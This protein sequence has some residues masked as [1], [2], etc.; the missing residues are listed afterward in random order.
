MGTIWAIGS[1]FCQFN[2]SLRTLVSIN[3]LVQRGKRLKY[4]EEGLGQVSWLQDGGV[5]AHVSVLQ[6]L[7]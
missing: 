5:P 1:C 4:P 6:R 7:R 3:Q 2:Y